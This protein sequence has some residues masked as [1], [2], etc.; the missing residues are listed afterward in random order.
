MPANQP[1]WQECVR[2]SRNVDTI[3][4]LSRHTDRLKQ[5]NC[6]NTPHSQS[7]F[8][9]HAPHFP[10]AP[11]NSISRSSPLITVLCH[12]ISVPI[13]WYKAGPLTL[14][15]TLSPPPSHSA[16]APSLPVGLSAPCPF[17]LPAVSV[18]TES[19]HLLVIISDNNLKTKK[20]PDTGPIQRPSVVMSWHIGGKGPW[21]SCG[22]VMCKRLPRA[23]GKGPWPKVWAG[24]EDRWFWNVV[25]QSLLS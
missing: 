13:S 12:P 10:R 19:F 21:N 23:S 9:S 14:Q 16:L 6:C 1:I 17:S 24:C 18:S 22:K 8:F 4:S 5:C 25:F 11:H 7:P 20:I 15:V 2:N 3:H